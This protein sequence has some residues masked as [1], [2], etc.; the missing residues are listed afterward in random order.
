MSARNLHRRQRHAFGV[1]YGSSRWRAASL[2]P[3]AR[4]EVIAGGRHHSWPADAPGAA[5][6]LRDFLA[7]HDA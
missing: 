5:R 1:N 3:D 2:M 6:S 7:A 4:V